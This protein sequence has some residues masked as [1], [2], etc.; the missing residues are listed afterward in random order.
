MDNDLFAPVREEV[1][2]LRTVHDTGFV[3]QITS[4][5]LT[6]AGLSTAARLGEEVTFSPRPDQHNR[7]EITRLAGDIITVMPYGPLDGI[8]IGAAVNLVGPPVLTPDNSWIGRVLDPFG[9]PMDGG[10]LRQGR[11]AVPVLAKAPNAHGRQ[12]LGPRLET[13]IGVLD[14]FLPLAQGQRVGLFAGSGV[15]KSTL[16]G[17]LAK[18]V[19]ADVIVI[20]LIGERGRELQ[21]FIQR[22]LGPE[23]MARCVIVAATSDLAPN[24]RRRAAWTAM[25][26]AE[27]FRDQGAH[28]L[29]MADS[30]TRF[31]E[32]YREVAVSAGEEAN[33]RGFPPSLT[34]ALASLC[35]RAGPGGRGQGMITAVMSVLVAGSDMEE[36]VADILRGLLDGHILLDR[37]I[38]E[39]GRYPAID[40][41]RSVSRCLPDAATPDENAVLS[42]ARKLMGAYDRSSMMIRAGL[43]E[44]GSDPQLDH[45][46][47]IFPALEAFFGNAA[48]QTISDSFDA[49]R[50]CLSNE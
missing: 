3:T 43:Y 47:A 17:R 8:A 45:A 29:F 32:A 50:T 12:L 49:L 20:A 21:E 30:L 11:R 18:Q 37:D 39:G 44:K 41:L 5:M 31:A 13:G 2:R 22:S 34:H 16:L 38:A 27:H 26:I 35:E 19:P 4:N 10:A 28:V 1:A 24:L 7:G 23:G 42:A 36:P 9:A 48:H 14:T 15:G 25:A 33:M 6:V 46:I 40:V